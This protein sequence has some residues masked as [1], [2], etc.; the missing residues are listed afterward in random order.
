LEHTAHN[1][2]QSYAGICT[3]DAAMYLKLFD[4]SIMKDNSYTWWRVAGTGVEP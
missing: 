4:G 3:Q 2:L 1:T